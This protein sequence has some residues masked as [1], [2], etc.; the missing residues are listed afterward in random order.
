MRIFVT[1]ATGFVGSAVVATLVAAGH[2]VTGLARSDAAAARLAAIGAD[3]HR[4]DVTDLASLAAGA[5]TADAVVHTAFNHDF[6]H[7]A[8]NCE[9]DRRAVLALGAALAGSRRPLLVT[10]GTGLL[11]AGRLATEADRVTAGA[12]PRA[13]TEAAADA[14]AAT[15]VRVACIRLPPSVHGDGDHGFVPLLIRL[16]RDKRVAAWIGDGG[17]RWSAVHRDDAADVYRLALERDLPADRFHAVAETGI[18]MRDIAAVIGRRLD[19][20]TAGLTGAAADAHFGWFAHFAGLDSHA[21]S[22]RSRDLLGWTPTRPGLLAD[23]DRPAYF[24]A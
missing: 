9:A 23:L 21:S 24:A 22:A 5:A 6:S 12:N 8:D 18:P 11:A 15:G 4:G 7:F 2:R 10:S 16:A 14:V 3:V 19:V 20:P 1:G 17:N 13:A